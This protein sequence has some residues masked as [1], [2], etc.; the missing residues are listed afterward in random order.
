MASET[1]FLYGEIEMTY[2]ANQTLDIFIE[3]M[4]FNGILDK[5]KA[6]ELSQFRA[7]VNKKGFFGKL[8]SNTLFKNND[9]LMLNIVKVMKDSRDI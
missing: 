9:S 3:T 7:V 5:E 2:L 6:E 8:I 4:V 1:R